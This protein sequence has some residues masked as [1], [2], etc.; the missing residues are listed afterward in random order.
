M[1]A[2]TLCAAIAIISVINDSWIVLRWMAEIGDIVALGIATLWHIMQQQQKGKSS[3]SI[4]AY[5]CGLKGDLLVYKDG[6][7]KR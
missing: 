1:P 5:A 6:Q 4:N 3:L 7:G 2:I